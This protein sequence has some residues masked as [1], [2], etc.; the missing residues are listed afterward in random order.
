MSLTVVRIKTEECYVITG[1]PVSLSLLLFFIRLKSETDTDM[2][3]FFWGI[4]RAM[5]QHRAQQEVISLDWSSPD[6]TSITKSKLTF[7]LYILFFLYILYIR[8]QIFCLICYLITFVSNLCIYFLMYL[9]KVLRLQ[10]FFMLSSWLSFSGKF[11]L[12]IHFQFWFDR[13]NKIL[14]CDKFWLTWKHVLVCSVVL[15][16]KCFNALICWDQVFDSQSNRMQLSLSEGPN[17]LNSALWLLWLFPLLTATL[18]YKLL[19]VDLYDI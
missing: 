18:L 14:D 9:N 8:D 1:H 12:Y 5:I 2:E 13:R 3:D 6:F 4:D 10:G 7:R 19:K 16:R 15:I 17:L 11:Y